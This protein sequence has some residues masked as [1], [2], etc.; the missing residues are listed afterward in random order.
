[1]SG[2]FDGDDF[3]GHSPFSKSMQALPSFFGGSPPWH[4]WGNTQQIQTNVELPSG[5]SGRPANP[6]VG[7][8]VKVAY[9]RPS[10]W[11]WI[12]SAKLISG[13]PSGS[14]TTNVNIVVA[15]E[16]TIGIGRSTIIMASQ[17]IFPSSGN[18]SPSFDV[19]SFTYGNQFPRNAQIWSTK[20][21]SPSRTFIVDPV[22]VAPVADA[23]TL[24]DT[25]IAQDIQL[26]AR[27]VA[28]AEA[29]NTALG[30][31]VVVEVSGQFSPVVHVRPD[32][33]NEGPNEARF[34]G[35]EIGGT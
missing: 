12:L 3:G 5:V 33:Y 31:P 6:G 29:P 21:Q 15:F 20:A 8:L 14:L 23:P 35:D 19:Q 32:W 4:L 17:L 7:Q 25:I 24:I 9:K 18:F 1:M 30:S 26:V 2:Q 27:V 10:A 11:N 34:G 28:T 22:G 13:P 16:L